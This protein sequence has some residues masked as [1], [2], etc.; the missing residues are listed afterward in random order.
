VGV[1]RSGLAN[2]LLCA[3]VPTKLGNRRAIVPIKK[4]E[5]TV[6]VIGDNPHQP[7]TDIWRA[8]MI[9]QAFEG[10]SVCS[11]ITALTE[12]ESNRTAG[13]EDPARWVTHFAGL[14]SSSSGKNLEPWIEILHG[15]TAVSSTASYRELVK[16]LCY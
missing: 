2:T 10:C 3:S 4:S 16:E 13:V 7:G 14:E 1:I 6:R 8:G 15:D 11:L 12:F 9:V 5:F